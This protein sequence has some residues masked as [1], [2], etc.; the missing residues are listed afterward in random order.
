MSNFHQKRKIRK[1]LYSPLTIVPLVVIVFL[2][3][4]SVWS[5]Y[6]K[7][8]ETRIKRDRQTAELEALEVRA[9]A[10]KTEIDRLGTERGREEE[11]RSK[12]EVAREGESVIVIVD[13]QK[14]VETE[15]EDVPREGFWG[16]IFNWF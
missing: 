3:G 9:S 13:P 16:R 2:L 8:R 10:L 4:T 5:V 14:E 12:F 6:T 11:I 1:F 7:E 15:A